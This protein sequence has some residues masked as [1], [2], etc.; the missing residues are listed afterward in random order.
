MNRF[1]VMK[2]TF[3]RSPLWSA[4]QYGTLRSY[5]KMRWWGIRYASPYWATPKWRR[6]IRNRWGV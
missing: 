5:F 1:Y 6:A 2:W 3:L 4:V